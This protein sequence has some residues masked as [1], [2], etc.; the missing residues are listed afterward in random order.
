MFPSYSYGTP[1]R[2]PFETSCQIRN[3]HELGP[4][5]APRGASG[6]NVEAA[7]GPVQFL[8]RTCEACPSCFG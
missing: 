2:I 4:E 3:Q 6:I 8:L 1:P 5:R 7:L